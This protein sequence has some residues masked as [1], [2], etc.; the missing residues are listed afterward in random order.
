MII[1]SCRLRALQETLAAWN[2]T[3][4]PFL[5]LRDG[6]ITPL[7][8]GFGSDSE[9][10]YY[11][12]FL[13]RNF[14]F[15][16]ESAL[17]WWDLGFALTAAVIA[18]VGFWNLAV[19]WA[20]RLLALLGVMGVALVSWHIGDTYLA[21]FFACS[22]M[23]WIFVFL[24][25][26]KTLPLYLFGMLAG[27]VM[28]FT[29]AI[30]MFGGYAL[31]IM[32][33]T[34][35]ALRM[36]KWKRVLFLLFACAAGMAV[37]HVWFNS[38][39]SA[40][41]AYLHKQGVQCEQHEFKHAFWHSI[42]VGLGFISNDL[43]IEYKDSCGLKRAREIKR[44]IIYCSPAYDVLLRNEAFR[45]CLS[46][47]MYV[48]RQLCAKAGILLFYFLL[49]ANIGLLAAFWY[50]KPWYIDLAYFLALCFAALP[51]LATIPILPYLVGF[52]SIAAFY[53]IHSLLWMMQKR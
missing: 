32:L 45:I 12:P 48:I 40:R 6:I 35:V 11:V 14:G 41:D 30:R 22:F 23:P 15:S 50:R 36:K 24:E 51:G 39:M 21:P 44:D 8:E 53:G 3:G 38:V 47:P 1:S 52:C 13:V 16:L 27:W 46:R 25:K 43:D 49:F 18:I 31:G 10:F 4:F 37:Y 20:Q 9:L 34:A 28:A 17:W 5:R 29:N 42:Y 26:N 19:T 7:E 33:L 2:Q